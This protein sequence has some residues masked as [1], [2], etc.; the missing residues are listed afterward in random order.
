MLG[1]RTAEALDA[2]RRSVRMLVDGLV[3]VGAAIAKIGRDVDNA[4][5][6]VGALGRTE[7]G[8]DQRG[9][10]PVWGGRE[11]GN[12]RLAGDE[13]LDVVLRLEA[14]FWEYHR[15][16]PEDARKRLARS[17]LR[18]HAEELEARMRGQ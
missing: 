11:E 3:G 12:A 16:V 6:A 13:A 18:E 4:H 14:L 9:G 8:I 7:Q 1:Q 15:Q 10:H 2:V 17:A 5:T